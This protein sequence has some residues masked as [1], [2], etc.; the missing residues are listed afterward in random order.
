MS[1]HG[2]RSLGWPTPI[3]A[4]PVR[5]GW[6][7]GPERMDIGVWASA[8]VQRSEHTGIGVSAFVRGLLWA[9]VGPAIASDRL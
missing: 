5:G 4:E 6:P 1:L 3:R 2:G 8:L 9:T 7:I